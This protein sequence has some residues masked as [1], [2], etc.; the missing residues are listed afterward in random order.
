[1]NQRTRTPQIIPA[2]LATSIFLLPFLAQAASGDVDLSF[3]PGSGP[4]GDVYCVATQPDGKALI[5]GA[6]TSVNG[7]NRNHI[8]RLNADGSLDPTFDPG[9]GANDI[10]I[11]LAPMADGKVVIGG[12][13]TAFDGG[14]RSKLA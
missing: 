12:S 7:T 1:M 10:V 11:V 14:D 13:F 6:F 2:L 8:A 3:D 4:N 9:Q 5:G